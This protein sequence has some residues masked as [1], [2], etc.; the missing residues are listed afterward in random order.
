M[1]RPFWLGCWGVCAVERV[2]R[3][4]PP[5]LG[6]RLWR[7]GVRVLLFFVFFWGGRVVSWLCCVSRSL[8]RSWVSWSLSPHPLSSGL[9]FFRP[10]VVCVRVFW[11]SL[12]PVGRC[13]RLGVAGFGWVVPLCPFGGPVFGAV[14]VGGLAA[15]CGVGGLLFRLWAFL[16]PLP[17]CLYLFFGGVCLFLPLP[18]LGWRTHWSALRVV[19]RVAVGGCVLPGRGPAPC[20]GWV[21]YT[22]GSS[23]LPAELGS[24]SA[25]WAA[26]RGGFVWPWVRGAGVFRVL[27]TPRC[28]F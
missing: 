21:M 9:L 20:I 10:S 24:G 11:V 22:L 3:L 18:S 15:S 26:A 27:S 23:P 2:P 14:R 17:P 5:F 8:S 6:G 7:G 16:A 25:G 4:P 19:F 12:C 28:R 13:S 1:P